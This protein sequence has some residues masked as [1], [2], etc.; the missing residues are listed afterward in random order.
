MGGRE[1]EKG[2][3]TGGKYIQGEPAQWIRGDRL[4]SCVEYT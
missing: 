3:G 4:S 2:V 1:R